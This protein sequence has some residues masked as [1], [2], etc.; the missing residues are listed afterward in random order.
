MNS[1]CLVKPKDNCPII[2]E[3]VIKTKFIIAND[4]ELV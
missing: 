4:Y 1:E 2:I 3:R